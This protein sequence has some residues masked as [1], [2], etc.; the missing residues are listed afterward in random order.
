MHIF[1][2]NFFFNL[3]FYLFI[4]EI[5]IVVSG[6]LSLNAWP[7]NPAQVPRF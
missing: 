2:Q 3:C 6:S 4:L 1:K 5:N 7:T